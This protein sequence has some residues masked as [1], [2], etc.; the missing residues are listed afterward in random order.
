MRSSTIAAPRLS[1]LVSLEC[2]FPRLQAQPTISERVIAYQSITIA[3]GVVCVR[4]AMSPRG[5][6]RGAIVENQP[7]PVTLA[8]TFTRPHFK[9]GMLCMAGLKLTPAIRCSFIHGQHRV[10][11]LSG[12]PLSHELPLSDAGKRAC[13]RP[14]SL[15]FL[16]ST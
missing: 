4:T 3:V 13:K 7:R 12:G 14:A 2:I 5:A 9:H 6:S 8:I 15:L 10:R 1:F 16:A 11:K